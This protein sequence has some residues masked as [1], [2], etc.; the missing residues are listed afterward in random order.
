MVMSGRFSLKGGGS[1]RV[2]TPLRIQLN[3]VECGAV[4]LGIVLEYYG[5]YHTALTL[6]RACAVGRDG[7]S[8]GQIK[9]GAQ[10]FGHSCRIVKVGIERLKSVQ[11]PIILH[12]DMRHFVV[13]EG[14]EGDLV[15]INDPA[16]GRRKILV[17]ELGRHFTGIALIV[18][19][20]SITF[21]GRK[22]GGYRMLFRLIDEHVFPIKRM[23]VLSAFSGLLLF[24]LDLVFVGV[25]QGFFDY[26]VELRLANWG[27][28]FAFFGFFLLAARF[29]LKWL[30]GVRR[31]AVTFFFADR[32]KGRFLEKFV[33]VAPELFDSQ[34]AG[35]I[36]GKIDSIDRF[37]HFF[38]DATYL[39][40]GGVGVLVAATACLAIVAPEILV[41]NFL[42]VFFLA[43][44]VWVVSVRGRERI[45]RGRDEEARYQAIEMQQAR[46]GT[47]FY[48]MGLQNY[49]LGA[50][51]GAFL[52][53]Q[54]ARRGV[55]RLF[56]G[57][58]A[59]RRSL[60][61]LSVPL[62]SFIGAWLMIEGFLSYGGVIVVIMLSAAFSMQIN[63]VLEIFKRHRE[64]QPLVGRVADDLI[65]DGDTSCVSRFDQGGFQETLTTR[66][67]VGPVLEA[68]SIGYGYNG[69]DVDLF[70]DVSLFINEGEVVNLSGPSGVGKTTLLEI[71]AGIR[72][73]LQG[74]VYFLGQK[75]VQP[76]C[77]GFVFSEDE[78]VFGSLVDFITN[79]DD[80]DRERLIRVLRLSELWERLGFI[81]EYDRRENLEELNLSRGEVQ[82]LFIAQ[83]LYR[84][85]R[86]IFFD[87]AFSHLSFDQS[88][89]IL[90]SLRKIGATL[91]LSTHRKEIQLLSDRNIV[92]SGL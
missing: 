19:V 55:E 14:V 67:S 32:M 45:V 40:G 20:N 42:S 70:C 30:S 21:S 29:F 63:G 52:R 53:L 8:V 77:V 68:R 51:M 4:C 43:L 41:L 36:H 35:E 73:P 34:F 18:T 82:R 44:W 22:R 11:F 39:S 24:I 83:A 91:V 38:L 59:A 92:L 10:F 65:L 25:V 79:G 23:I 33:R 66:S 88:K 12:W 15:W 84:N 57:V 9:R 64:L 48:A 28:A 61:A 54:E 26:V 56:S 7:S 13:I 6:R 87:E 76:A 31:H 46:G 80:L 1:G 89:R 72:R 3:P 47:R 50:S 27:Y 2:I 71:L 81:A 78:F 37:I 69:T 17:S 49:M 85:E 62:T 74:E 75:L 90:E 16:S 86:I 60:E 58:S 5:V